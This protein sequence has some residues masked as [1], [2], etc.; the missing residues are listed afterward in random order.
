[1]IDDLSAS[2]ARAIVQEIKDILSGTEWSADT[3]DDI[4]NALRAWGIEVREVD[5]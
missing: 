1:M 2:Q 3:C 4:A 5:E